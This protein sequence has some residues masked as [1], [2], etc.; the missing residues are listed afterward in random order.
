[1]DNQEP[2]MYLILREDLAYKYIQGSHVL[3]QYAMDHR[4]L[5][6]EWENKYLI[7]MSVFNGLALEEIEE[8]LR[9]DCF[10]YS[11]FYEPDLK[12]TLPSGIAIFENGDGKVA[13]HLKAIKHL[14]M[15]TK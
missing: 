10:T 12:S 11:A 8:K 2:R 6:E 7:C 5:F 4:E 1:M 3:A 9:F 14:K 13:N 15:S